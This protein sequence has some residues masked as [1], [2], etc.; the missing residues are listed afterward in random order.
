VPSPLSL[1][2]P[3]VL[4]HCATAFEGCTCVRT[5]ISNGEGA[6]GRAYPFCAYSGAELYLRPLSK[7]LGPSQGG[8][9]GQIPT[10]TTVTNC[11]A[12]GSVTLTGSTGGGLIAINSG[13]VS[14][15][16]WDTQT[17][18]MATSA[19]GTG[20]T[21]AQMLQ[22][23]TFASWDMAAVAHGDINPSSIWNIVDGGSY[24]HFGWLRMRFEL[25]AGWNMVSVPRELPPGKNTVAEIF[26]G[27]IVA[28]YTWNPT[29]KSY[30]VPA[31]V[32]PNCGYWVAVTEDKTI[33]YLMTA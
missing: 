31:T 29:A 30:V 1:C 4:R 19:G 24:P 17:T 28:I 20:K 16:F 18:G 32:E 26:E 7:F 12:T 14:G 9:L 2:S 22:E 10:G 23:A 25:K 27:E 15:S 33:A 13:T 21:T 5:F 3:S 11:Y 8:L 6:E